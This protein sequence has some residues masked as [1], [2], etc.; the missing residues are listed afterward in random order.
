MAVQSKKK[1]WR[2]WA[3]AMA[4]MVMVAGVGVVSVAEAQNRGRAAAKK[5]PPAPPPPPPIR[6]GPVFS[7][8]PGVEPLS[9]AVQTYAMFH[10]DLGN[11]RG[12]PMRNA[13]ELDTALDK[14]AAYNP[15]H[16]SRGLLAYGALTA[17]QSEPFANTVRNMATFFGREKV[18]E[19]LILGEDYAR[20]L[21]GADDAER[22]IAAAFAAD[23]NRVIRVSEEYRSNAEAAQR[24]RWG[25]LITSGMAR[26]AGALRALADGAPMRSVSPE[27][28]PRLAPAAAS[29]NPRLDPNTFGGASFWETWRQA[30]TAGIAASTPP[31]VQPTP[32]QG[33]EKDTNTMLRLAALYILDATKDPA[34]P[35]GE[36]L[37]KDQTTDRCFDMAQVQLQ[38]CVSAARFHYETAF[39]L[40]EQGLQNVGECV[41]EGRQIQ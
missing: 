17:A 11:L 29:A 10:A 20:T 5:A 16:L 33:R 15:Y 22:L 19:G 24:A 6:T 25:G 3:A 18:I 40:A 41:R 39:C 21:P 2:L 38:Q 8:P 9:F 1:R 12:V 30:P 36:F 34:T 31:A 23:G 4:A 32:P 27:L 37:S 26:R 14:V 35:V 13:Q 28:T 7:A